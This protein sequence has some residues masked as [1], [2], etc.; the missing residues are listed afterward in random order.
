MKHFDC[1]PPLWLNIKTKISTKY[2]GKE[3]HLFLFFWTTIVYTV[4]GNP[5]FLSSGPCFGIM[6][7]FMS[8][9]TVPS[10]FRCCREIC[11]YLMI[12]GLLPLYVIYSKY[13]KL[14]C[15]NRPLKMWYQ[16]GFFQFKV[17]IFKSQTNTFSITD[18]ID[19]CMY[20]KLDLRFYEY[21]L[22]QLELFVISSQWWI[23]FLF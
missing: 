20:C 16:I 22:C 6:D 18:N 1:L 5:Y 17:Y 10:V 7:R 15:Q 14:C 23:F 3:E 8:I 11:L 9:L 21:F 4:Q 19:N 13:L 12:F 2:I